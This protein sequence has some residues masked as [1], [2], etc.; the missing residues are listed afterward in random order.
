MLKFRPFQRRFIEAV[1]NPAY[2]TVAL[3][4]PRGLGKT[5]IAAHVLA[6]CMTPGDPLHESGKEFIL[7]AASL[8]QARLTYGFIREALEPLGGY[9]FSDSSTRLGITHV[10]SNTKLRA[11]SSNPKTSFGLVG[12][13]LLCLDEPGALDIVGGGMLADS[14]FSAQGKPGS[15]LKVVM[16]GTL[17]PLATSQGHWWYDLIHAGTVGSTHIQHYAGTLEGWD[18]W[19]VIRRSN[20]LVEIDAGFRKKLLAERDAARID[21]RLK[22]RFL[23]YRL[24]IPSADDSTVLLTVQDWRR[25][26]EREVP[27]REGRPFVG[28]DLGG[29]RAWS[30]AVAWWPS[31]RVEC[32]GL[33]P[34]IPDI[35]AQEKRDRQPAGTYAR[36]VESGHLRI[37][38][39]LRVQPPKLLWEAIRETW[40]KPKLIIC[41][42]FRL[43]DMQDAVGNG[44]K[45]EA[46][47]TQ[48]SEASADI[49]ALR[50]YALDGPLSVERE[51]RRMLAVSLERAQVQCDLA[52]NF[53]LVKRG[54]NNTGRDDCASALTLVCGAV[55][56]NPK[57]RS[58]RFLGFA[59]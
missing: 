26:T 19:P 8:E 2:D 28:V 31:G 5:F 55:D 52:G 34:G 12:V 36:L 39:G 13:P 46:R 54:T 53:R 7:G 35:E 30:A 29:G 21:S 42:R 14:L 18:T 4:G 10:S 32:L 56:R 48:W 47:V 16:I 50:R 57:P 59:E 38:D 23:S 11:I 41:D 58:A 3:S 44:A 37:A 1:E 40:G 49:R 25:V 22:A 24:N 45:I 51:S 6:R 20:P 9:R 33:T 27:D 17:A 15:K 43:P